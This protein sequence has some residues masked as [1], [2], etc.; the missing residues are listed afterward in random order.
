MGVAEGRPPASKGAC[1]FQLLST[2]LVEVGVRG[3]V[4]RLHKA[5]ALSR[6]HPRRLL[7][8]GIIGA[9]S[10]RELRPEHHKTDRHE[11]QVVIRPRR[12]GFG[13]RKKVVL[14][15]PR[16]QA[17]ENHDFQTAC[18]PAGLSQRA[19]CAI[20]QDWAGRSCASTRSTDCRTLLAAHCP[21]GCF[22]MHDLTS[23]AW[24]FRAGRHLCVTAAQHCA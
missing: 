14:V 4:S 19:S 8:A 5:L 11:A 13:H 22:P 18:V 23:S 9:A 7:N 3:W 12:P 24:W 17:V 20:C 16:F 1:W 2:H 15:A 6:A 21:S 10:Q